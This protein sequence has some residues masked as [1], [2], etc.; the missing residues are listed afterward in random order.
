MKLRFGVTLPLCQR[1][2]IVV[3]VVM[4][5]VF[6]VH[7]AAPKCLI[8]PHYATREELFAGMCS[9]VVQ[10]WSNV[11]PH[12]FLENSIRSSSQSQLDTLAN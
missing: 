1:V 3:T 5:L 4:L 2:V 12:H 8:F 7:C 11:T 10:L 9:G 6:S